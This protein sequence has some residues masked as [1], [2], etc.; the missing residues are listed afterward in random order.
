MYMIITRINL[1]S[2]SVAYE[3]GPSNGKG[4]VIRFTY[5]ADKRPD[6]NSDLL[7]LGFI[8]PSIDAVL[9]RIGSHHDGDRDFIQLEI[10]R[11][12]IV[13]CSVGPIN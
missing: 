4:G 8:T 13:K 5:P 12:S 10:V 7:S 2:E 9:A 3:W 11:C 6:T 1:Y